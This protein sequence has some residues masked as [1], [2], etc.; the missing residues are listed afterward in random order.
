MVQFKI[1]SFT[2]NFKFLGYV[3][4]VVGGGVLDAELYSPEGKC[5]HKLAPLPAEISYFPY[6][7]V[8]RSQV[9]VCGLTP[10]QNCFVYDIIKDSWSTTTSM[11]TSYQFGFPGSAYQEK[12]YLAQYQNAKVFDPTSNSWS[13]WA[14]VPINSGIYG[15]MVTL[16][17]SFI[18][19]GGE[20]AFNTVLQY[21]HLSHSWTNLPFSY[22]PITVMSLP[23]C[24]VLPNQNVLVVSGI[25][26]LGNIYA[27]YNVTSNTWPNQT[28]GNTLHAYASAIV[29]GKRVF[30]ISGSSVNDIEEFNYNTISVTTKMFKLLT[31]RP[32]MP[33]S[34]ALPAYLFSHLPG[35]CLGVM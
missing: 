21:S 19:F 16:N 3:A 9:I 33:G 20:P 11:P 5:Q 13:S 27:V 8:F 14:G 6:L 22:P 26:Q 7:M 10:G 1:S 18:Y 25:T 34:I 24:V 30:I 23:S 31:T 2:L 29:L 4:F 32:L 35:G 17:D 12:F 15:C 28:V